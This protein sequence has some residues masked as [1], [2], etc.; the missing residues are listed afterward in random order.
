MKRV[1]LLLVAAIIISFAAPG[2]PDAM[3]R[4][5]GEATFIGENI[6]NLDG[7]YQTKEQEIETGDTATFFVKVENDVEDGRTRDNITVRGTDDEDGWLVRYFDTQG[8]GDVTISVITTG[9]ATGRLQPHDDR[10]LQVELIAESP[11]KDT[12]EVLVTAQSQNQGSA[13]DAVKAVA[14]V[15]LVS[16][17]ES[18]EHLDEVSL[19]LPSVISSDSRLSISVPSD[20]NVTVTMF[21][22]AGEKITTLVSERLDAGT[23]AVPLSITHLPEGV[24]F[25]VLSTDIS[26]VSRKVVLLR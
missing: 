14:I 17:A 21:N 7:A 13:K 19:N 2:R 1:I 11:E 15:E 8:G 6:Y 10:L 3:I 9:W 5:E 16:S 25:C 12:F 4:N 20:C 24:Y 22:A 26:S 18:P 23:R